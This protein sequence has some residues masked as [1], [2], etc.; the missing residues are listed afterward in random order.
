MKELFGV[1]W[2]RLFDPPIA[3]KGLWSADTCPENSLGAFQA[4]CGTGDLQSGQLSAM[5]L[6]QHRP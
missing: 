4:A 3:H 6:A 5:W 1:A 2:E